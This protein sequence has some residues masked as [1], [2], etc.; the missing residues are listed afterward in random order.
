MKFEYDGSDNRPK[1]TI[2][3]LKSLRNRRESESY[4]CVLYCIVDGIRVSVS[5]CMYT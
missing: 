2:L 3:L 4:L 5:L 1:Q